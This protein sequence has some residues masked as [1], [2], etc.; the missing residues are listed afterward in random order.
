MD[1]VRGRL[2]KKQSNQIKELQ[3]RLQQLGYEFSEEMGEISFSR[4]GRLESVLSEILPLVE[5]SGWNARKELYLEQ[6]HPDKASRSIYENGRIVR[7]TPG[8]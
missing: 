3:S 4:P 1:Q 8:Y 6:T 2:P 7:L 5:K